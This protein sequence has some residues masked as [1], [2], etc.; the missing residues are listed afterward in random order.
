MTDYVVVVALYRMAPSAA[1]GSLGV[2]LNLTS[3]IKNESDFPLKNTGGSPD[4]G[5]AC[6]WQASTR[7]SDPFQLWWR[8]KSVIR[9]SLGRRLVNLVLLQYRII[10]IRVAQGT[11]PSTPGEDASANMKQANQARHP[12]TPQDSCHKDKEEIRTNKKKRKRKSRRIKTPTENK[13]K[14][15]RFI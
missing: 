6:C 13:R 12:R 8:V 2:G 1:H 10:N 4:I 5:T 9:R 14:G 3:T 7:V 11:M 15:E